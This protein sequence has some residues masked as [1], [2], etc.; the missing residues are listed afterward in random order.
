MSAESGNV[1]ITD[2]KLQQ[3]LRIF[4]GNDDATLNEWLDLPLPILS[5]QCPRNMLN[6]TEGRQRLYQI[7]EEM[8]FGEMA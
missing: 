8:K 3:E 6:T 5:G 2:E 1:K 7:L 4:F